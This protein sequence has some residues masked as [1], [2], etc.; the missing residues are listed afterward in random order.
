[1]GLNAKFLNRNVD[2][3]A[4]PALDSLAGQKFNEQNYGATLGIP[5]S[6]NKGIF[7]YTFKSIVGFTGHK[8]SEYEK[9]STLKGL[10]FGSI[11]SS[12]SFSALQL[13]AKQ[14][15][16]PRWGIDFYAQYQKSISKEV[17]A[18]RINAEGNVYIPGLMR[19]HGIKLT[20]CRQ[21]ELTSNDFRF[22][23]YFDYARGYE[24]RP[25]DEVYKISVDYALPLFY[26]DW[27]FASFTY[28]KRIKADLFYDISKVKYLG[29]T[30]DQ[31][32]YGAEIC[33]D[34]TI[35]DI[36]PV[37][38]GFRESFLL[39]DDVLNPDMKNKFE[40]VFKMGF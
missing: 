40:V 29:K 11:A 10:D 37:S 33:F 1:M 13:Q 21:K 7:N 30:A 28:F 20:Y 15:L 17:E 9:P 19:N 12:I 18:E 36:I 35:L 39:N 31:N 3:F 14:N 16:M 4:T 25:N 26:P 27:G 5:L 22:V 23:D 6:W 8:T 38:F 34:N 24:A 2:Y 32:S